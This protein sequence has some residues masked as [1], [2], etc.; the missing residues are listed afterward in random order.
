MRSRKIAAAIVSLLFLATANLLATPA[1]S[2]TMEQT[3]RA[4]HH[5]YDLTMISDLEE[6]V[7]KDIICLALNQYHEARGSSVSDIKAVGFSTRNRVRYTN[8]SSFC[9]AIW[10]K[11]QY[12]WT[13][14]SVSNILPKD[15]TSWLKMIGF[16]REIV[17]NDN[18]ADTTKGADSFYSRKIPT[19]RWARKSPIRVH[20]GSHV[21]VRINRKS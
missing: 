10:K 11:G 13:K 3:T 1:K 2:A 19:P 5:K 14:R 6:N 16:A 8:A 4:I 17:T 7:Q 18:L 20:I 15:K 9:K 12:I 21:Y